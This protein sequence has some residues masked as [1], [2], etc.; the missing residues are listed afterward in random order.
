LL[1]LAGA[2]LAWRTERVLRPPPRALVHRA[3]A[4]VA[5]ALSGAREVL[6]NRY[7]LCIVSIVVAYEFAAATT[8]FVINV[9]FERSFR[10]EVELAQMYGRLGWIVS[11]TALLC[12]L[13]V[14]PRLLPRKRLALLIPPIAMVA[15]TVGL[16]VLPVVSLAVVLAA[17][18][19]GLNYSLQQVTKESLY[20]PLNDAQKYKAKA[21]IDVFVDRAAKALS[22]VALLLIIGWSGVSVPLCLGVALAALAVWTVA[23][24]A[25]GR[26]YDVQMARQGAAAQPGQQVDMGPLLEQPDP[27][28]K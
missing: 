21:F 15:A 14:V 19:R 25:L 13:F 12:Q 17:S 7:L 11:G 16:A 22:S 9:V 27:A 23:A 28:G 24:S 2:G 10:T 1:V 8:D 20:V 6:G 26:S 5:D 18:D 3:S 4:P